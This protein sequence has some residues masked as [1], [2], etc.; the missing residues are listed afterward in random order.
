MVKWIVILLCLATVTFAQWTPIDYQTVRDV[1][2]TTLHQ[3]RIGGELLFYEEAEVWQ[4]IQ[5]GWTEEGHG[6]NKIWVCN[7][8]VMQAS[9]NMDG[10]TTITVTWDDTTYQIEHT[11]SGLIIEN[12]VT[13]AQYA[14][15]A[16]Q[17][18]DFG[19]PDIYGDTLRWEVGSGLIY[20]A[21]KKNATVIHRITFEPTFSNIVVQGGQMLPDFENLTLSN[22]VDY[23]FTNITHPELGNTYETELK[24]FGRYKLKMDRQRMHWTDNDS[25]FVPVVQHWQSGKMRERVPIPNIQAIMNANPNSR[26]WHNDETTIGAGDIEDA[27]IM[28]NYNDDVNYG[29]SAHIYWSS[30]G[31]QLI[32]VMNVASNLGVDATI[33]A[34]VCSLKTDAT[35]GSS[36]SASC[37]RVFKPWIEGT[38][39]SGTNE[40]GA[41]GNDWDNDDWEW[42]TKG[43]AS[44]DDGGSD[45]SG[46]GTGAD[47]KATAEGSEVLV[48]DKNTWYSWVITNALA[49]GWY[50]ETIGERGILFVRTDGAGFTYAEST[51]EATAANRPR[52]SFTYTTGGAPAAAS[53]SQ[54]IIIN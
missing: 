8:D 31:Y 47:R 18:P 7:T 40:P 23:V 38:Q 53:Q 26:I 10:V 50:D 45:N 36:C 24:N 9:V 12:A 20:E 29:A 3:T 51:E 22:D 52:F 46:D 19:V 41:T 15:M 6:P 32:R 54:V 35:F 2:D 49:Q 16:G 37:Y 33:T 1:V 48:A 4:P 43:C 39:A 13:N 25:T 5:T 44:A 17:N 11:F 27:Y 14:L 28:T 34:A 30:V 21:I 42:T